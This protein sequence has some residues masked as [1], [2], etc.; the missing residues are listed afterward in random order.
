MQ[1][2]QQCRQ[3]RGQLWLLPEGIQLPIL[4]LSRVRVAD[5]MRPGAA[6]LQRAAILVLALLLAVLPLLLLLRPRSLA[7]RAA[8]ASPVLLRR[9]CCCVRLLRCGRQL[10][11]ALYTQG[12]HARVVQ[13]RGRGGTAMHGSNPC[14]RRPAHRTW[15]ERRVPTM[16]PRQEACPSDAS[17]QCAAHKQVL[18]RPSSHR[19]TVSKQRK[20]AATRGNPDAVVQGACNIWDSGK[21]EVCGHSMHS[22]WH[23]AMPLQQPIADTVLLHRFKHGAGH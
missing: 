11:C 4:L 1:L 6:I 16:G 14:V 10:T 20:I 9:R 2:L 18:W 23:L 7:R 17:G 8:C 13:G 21:Y 15:R 22:T 19:L 3:C 5:C 12:M